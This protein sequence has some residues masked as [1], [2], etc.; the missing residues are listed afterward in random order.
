MPDTATSR[1]D[2]GSGSVR[3]TTGGGVR[4]CEK[5]ERIVPQRPLDCRSQPTDWPSPTTTI[6][7][8]ALLPDAS[9]TAAAA[10]AAGARIVP[11][12]GL[13]AWSVSRR[14]R[15]SE[16]GTGFITSGTGPPRM[17]EKAVW[18]PACSRYLPASSTAS[19]KLLLPSGPTMH[20]E[21]E[22]SMISAT[23]LLAPPP[24]RLRLSC[25]SK[26]I[27]A[28]TSAP[29]ASAAAIARARHFG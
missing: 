9:V 28:A 21:D 4:I 16:T 27:A 7:F 1:I 14:T 5:T 26:R 6:C 15:R 8:T 17:I 11:C 12:V 3:Q 10:S 18:R 23:S 2:A 25:R 22:P 24:K 20:I 13:S 19:S 29:I